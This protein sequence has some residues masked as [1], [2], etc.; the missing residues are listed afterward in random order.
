MNTV[1]GADGIHRPLARRANEIRI[2]NI[3]L[4]IRPDGFSGFIRFLRHTRRLFIL[5]KVPYY[6]K[7]GRLF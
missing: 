4:C 5:K 7:R 1:T 2:R 3:M 6:P